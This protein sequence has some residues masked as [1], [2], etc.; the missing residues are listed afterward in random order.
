[1]VIVKESK[2]KKSY[3]MEYLRPYPYDRSLYIPPFP[4]HFETPKFDKYKRKGDP[5]DHIRYFFTPC[6]EVVHE[7]TYILRLFP[8]SL[9]EP[10]LEWFSHLPPRITSWGKLAKLF[11]YNFSHNIDNLVSLIDLCTTKQK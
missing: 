11:I 5:R 7:D 3:T 9:G 1:M 6:I 8:K 10:A 2:D 4:P